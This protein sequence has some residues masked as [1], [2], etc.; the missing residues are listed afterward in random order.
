MKKIDHKKL[1][2]DS[3]IGMTIGFMATLIIA[4][5]FAI[6]GI[7]SKDNVFID[8]KKGLTYITPFAIGVAVGAK[9]NKIH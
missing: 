6:I 5:I 7:Y 2:I 1:W 9:L 3:M 8:I 4:Q